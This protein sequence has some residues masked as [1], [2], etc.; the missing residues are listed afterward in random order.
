[1]RNYFY[2]LAQEKEQMRKAHELLK[3]REEEM[4]KGNKEFL[5]KSQVPGV[6]DKPEVK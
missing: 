3:K 5:L 1:M 6:K 2:R 4:K